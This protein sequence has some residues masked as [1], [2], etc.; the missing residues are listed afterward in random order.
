MKSSLMLR[1][2]SCGVEENAPHQNCSAASENFDFF[3]TKNEK[4]ICFLFLGEN[5][6][7]DFLV[8]IFLT[9]CYSV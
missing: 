5:E 8:D 1:F 6:K 3:L 9:F 7:N 2:Q 4:K